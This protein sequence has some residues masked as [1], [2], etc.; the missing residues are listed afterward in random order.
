MA[1]PGPA[2]RQRIISPWSAAVAMDRP[3]GLKRA[4]FTVVRWARRSHSQ[5]IVG[6]EGWV[7]GM[8]L[9]DGWSRQMRATLSPPAVTRRF[10][11]EM[12]TLQTGVV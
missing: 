11:L 3:V 12:S 2:K 1:W 8:L 6:G 7:R 9:V 4:T 5:S 10:V